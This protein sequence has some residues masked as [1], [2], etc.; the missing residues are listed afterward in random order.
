MKPYIARLVFRIFHGE[1]QDTAV[2]EEQLR[3]LFAE[4]A[5]E[6]DEKAREIGI[7]ENVTLPQ[8]ETGYVKWEF[9]GIMELHQPD[10]LS[11]GLLLTSISRETSDP[12]GFLEYLAYRESMQNE[13]SEPV[14]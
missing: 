8:I 13:A 5:E 2:F 12:K 1:E 6:A 14:G 3:L 10:E 9:I 4:S 7:A 11:N